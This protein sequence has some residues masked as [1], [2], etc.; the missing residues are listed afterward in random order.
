M[1]P[2]REGLEYRVTSMPIRRNRPWLRRTAATAAILSAACTELPPEL[3]ALLPAEPAAVEPSAVEQPGPPAAA[4]DPI[5]MP[6]PM[7][8]ATPEPVPETSADA[9]KPEPPSTDA[10]KAGVAKLSAPLRSKQE[11]PPFG[12]D[13]GVLVGMGPSEVELVVGPPS[14]IRDEP[15]A[16]VWTYQTDRCALEIFFYREIQTQRPRALAYA[17][18]GQDQ[19]DVAK[20]TCFSIVRAQRRT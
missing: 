14:S 6:A 8:V 11:P 10:V 7:T 5:D 3:V 16:T 13:P 20:Q 12:L 4:A 19:T 1:V 18:K 2:T 17:V 9:Q 15:P